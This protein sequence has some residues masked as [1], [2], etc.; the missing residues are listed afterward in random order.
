MVRKHLGYG[1]IPARF[2]G[3][4]NAFSQQVLSPYLNHHGPW[5]FPTEAIDAKGRI[6]KYYR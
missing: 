1:H 3:E 5:Y 2:A 4:V 6:R